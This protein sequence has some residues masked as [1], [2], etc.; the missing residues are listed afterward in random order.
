[1][2]EWKFHGKGFYKHSNEPSLYIKGGESLDKLSDWR[3]P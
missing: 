2:V 1:M 3:L